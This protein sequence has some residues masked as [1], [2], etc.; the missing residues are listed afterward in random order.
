M[1]AIPGKLFFRQGIFDDSSSGGA[2][3]AFLREVFDFAPN[4]LGD[5]PA[6]MA[7]AYFGAEGRCVA[8]VEAATL[9]VIVDGIIG[10]A[11]AIRLAGVAE[12]HRGRGLFRDL[13]TRALAWCATQSDG[14]ILLY[15]EEHALYTRFGFQPLVEHA[16]VGP[17]PTPEAAKAA[18]I[19][20]PAQAARLLDK[21]TPIRAPLSNVCAILG[22]S[23]LL[24]A[25]LRGDEDFSLAYAADL[26][27]L[28]VHEMQDDSL[29]LVDIVA[30]AIPSMARIVGAL[31]SSAGRVKTLFPPDRLAW[32][33]APEPDETGL[34]IRGEVPAAMRRPF[35]LPPTMSF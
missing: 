22:G 19:I 16:F 18:E 21:L 34:M 24:R 33:G 30:A 4:R 27:A 11:T 35:M 23:D 5:D 14:P 2:Y 1:K 25:A 10:T 31:R 9:R 32:Q 13:M 7:F 20:D 26:E 12:T 17:P 6:W 29:V 3:A 28:I 8:G 15:T